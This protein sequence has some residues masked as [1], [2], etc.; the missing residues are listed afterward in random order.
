MRLEALA[1]RVPASDAY[2]VEVRPGDP[3]V[4]ETAPLVVAILE[5]RRAGVDA[6]VIARRFHSWVVE[7]VAVVCGRLRDELG[8]RRV[9]LSGGVFANAI[10]SNEIPGRLETDGFSVFQHRIVPPNDGGLALG[11]LAVACHGG[12]TRLVP[13]S[14]RVMH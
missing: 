10:L 12:G 1:S 8:L 14:E 4:L 7:A 11:Q 3:L 13:P 6:S 9:V 5:D 2:P